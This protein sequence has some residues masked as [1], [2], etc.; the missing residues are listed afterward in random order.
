MS[1]R[2]IWLYTAGVGGFALVWIGAG[3]LAALGAF[4]M[5]AAHAVATR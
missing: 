2:Q 4:M 5:L 3:F 1:K